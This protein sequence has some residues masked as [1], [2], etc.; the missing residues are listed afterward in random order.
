M[1]ETLPVH[2]HLHAGKK[3]IV[4]VVVGLGVMLKFIE[5]VVSTG[6]TGKSSHYSS[7]MLSASILVF[8][9]V[10]YVITVDLILQMCF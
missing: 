10:A 3:V 4:A 7:N 8:T 9:R 1:L 2:A 6:I 5:V